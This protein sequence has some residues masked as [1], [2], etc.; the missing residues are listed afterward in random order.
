LP[1]VRELFM[2]AYR[3]DPKRLIQR[4]ISAEIEYLPE[5]ECPT[6]KHVP[7]MESEADIKSPNSPV[8]SSGS[9]A[10]NEEMKEEEI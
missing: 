6:F 8:V 10:S 4:L 5:S 9:N 1:E 3:K 7:Y 2:S